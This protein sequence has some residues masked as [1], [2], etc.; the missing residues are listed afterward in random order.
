MAQ[1]SMSTL[2]MVESQRKGRMYL[3][4]RGGGEIVTV[5]SRDHTCVYWA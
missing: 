2:H 3:G 5:Q 1:F 4:R